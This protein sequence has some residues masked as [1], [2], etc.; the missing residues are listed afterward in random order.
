MN[1]HL[2]ET[3]IKKTPLKRRF[4]LPTGF[5]LAPKAAKKQNLELDK[6]IIEE[7][8]PLLQDANIKVELESESSE[9]ASTDGNGTQM[10]ETSDINGNDKNKSNH[11]GT[12]GEFEEFDKDRDEIVLD[13]PIGNCKLQNYTA[14]MVAKDM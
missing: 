1:I 2:T 12:E 9:L 4:N 13:D 3:F 8:E 10:D 5:N 6:D 7:I 14:T 11:F